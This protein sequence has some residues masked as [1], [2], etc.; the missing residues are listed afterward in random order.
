MVDG[1]GI[2]AGASG[3]QR[4]R[5]PLY[6]AS[7]HLQEDSALEA[8]VRGTFTVAGPPRWRARGMDMH[9][10]QER[11]APVRG[12][13]SLSAVNAA[14]GHYGA[15]A[16][17]TSTPTW[18]GRPQPRR[19]DRE[20]RL[21][22][23]AEGVHVLDLV[24]PVSTAASSGRILLHAWHEMLARCCIGSERSRIDMPLHIAYRRLIP[25]PTT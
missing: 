13:R 25:I 18:S 16:T 19:R 8:R 4:R 1:T 21:P 7:H 5:H 14:R 2:S 22:A 9:Y 20:R 6:V 24:D 11:S 3:G 15:A 17:P 12:V 23:Q 10:S